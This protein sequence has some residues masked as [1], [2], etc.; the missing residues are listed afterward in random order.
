MARLIPLNNL[1]GYGKWRSLMMLLCITV[2][3]GALIV[4]K[5]LASIQK[6]L[7]EMNQ[8]VRELNNF[9][10]HRGVIDPCSRPV[11]PPPDPA[12][13]ARPASSSAF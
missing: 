10:N 8:N 1:C 2:I 7:K 12:S 3:V 4:G 6:K 11:C 13:D 5:P 9:F